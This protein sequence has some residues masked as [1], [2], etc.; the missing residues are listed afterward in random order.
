MR[1]IALALVFWRLACPEASTAQES[2]VRT[3]FH[4]KQVAGATVYLDAGSEEGLAE[5]M[6]LRVSRRRP[7]DALSQTKEVAGLTVVAV[8]THTAACDVVAPQ[9]EVQA[10]DDAA[11]EDADAQVVEITKAAGARH[12]YA[13]LVSFSE[14]DP[15]E[16]EARSYVP[17]PTSAEVN[18]IRGRFGFEQ[19]AILDH[20]GAGFQSY[21]EGVVLRAD[22]TRIGGTFWNFSGYWRGRINTRQGG[23]ETLNDLL[24]RTYHIG[25]EYNKPT[26]RYVAGFGRFLLP[27]ASSLN[28][29]DGGYFGRKLG[30]HATAGI[31]AGSTPDPTAWNYDPNRQL[32]GT[33]ISWEHGS[34]DAFRY[35]GTAGAAVTRL[36]WR[37]ERQFLFFENSFSW[38]T[39]VSVYHNLEADQLSPRLTS[40]GNTSPRIAR[41]FFTLR[42]QPNSRVAIDFNHNYFRGVPTFDP[43]L[44]GTGL[45]DKL[46][47]QGLSAGV[48]VQAN[49]MLSVYGSIGS[50]KRDQDT[51]RA[52]NEMAGFTVNS[53][54]WFPVRTDVR[55]SRF[56]SSF[57]T[58]AYESVSFMR[59]LGERLRL[60]AQ[61]GQQQIQ[62]DY[63]SQSR[64]RFINTTLDYMIGS[65]YIIGAG[66][67]FY[68]GRIQNYDQIY[69][70]LGY[71]F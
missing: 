47:F 58:G 46:L 28:T 56:N 60:E 2:A 13:Q 7:G 14:G 29:I 32:L 55:Y 42:L 3:V 31:F 57:G 5:G 43:R 41:S 4:V 1:R 63:T 39:V 34:F 48:R 10:G 22:M 38:K 66:W 53:F 23:P 61:A 67:T 9:L 17:H 33:F 52:L 27:W 59:N 65:H 36:H 18:R 6:K 68:R 24:N 12:R 16:E 62:S 35:T 50:N 19:N 20:T 45:L 51:Q 25:F 21:Q 54:K 69:L 30:S 37:P 64:S 71:R 11:L 44:I 49:R 40:D 26:G 8:A 15:L 70:N